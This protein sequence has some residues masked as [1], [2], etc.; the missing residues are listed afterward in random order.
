[1]LGE[2]TQMRRC[3]VTMTFD[4]QAKCT[5]NL[6]DSRLHKKNGTVATQYN[7]REPGLIVDRCKRSNR[8][9]IPGSLRQLKP[10]ATWN[11][12]LHSWFYMYGHV[13]FMSVDF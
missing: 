8:Y 11:H 4:G 7:R 12:L 9:V 5:G 1:M 3:L 10:L 6:V 13:H 2:L